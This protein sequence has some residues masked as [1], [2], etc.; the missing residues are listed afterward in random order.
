MK[1]SKIEI[2]NGTLYKILK[3]MI[4]V[5]GAIVGLSLLSIVLL[6][7]AILIKVEDPKGKV[8]FIQ[9]RVG[10]HGTEF[11]MYKFRSMCSNAEEKLEGLM[12]YNE[13]SG[14]MFKMKNDPR[15]TKVGRFIRK[16]SIDELPQLLNVL[17]GE[18]SLV[19]PRPP[20]P[21]EVAQYAEYHMQRLMVIPGC[22]GLWQISGRN[23]L[24]FDQMVELD[25][26]Y[27]KK[28]NT[29]F[30]LK[31]IIK[32]MGSLLNTKNTF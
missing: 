5:T 20:L 31:I 16:T 28:R 18:M 24:N 19:G 11:N 21:R 32:T 8:F 17:K 27:I 1:G 12:K 7:V 4:D 22:T 3:R 2:N 10:L 13:I 26:F 9:R 15:I 23:S 30:D 6:A 14:A 29:L 25:L